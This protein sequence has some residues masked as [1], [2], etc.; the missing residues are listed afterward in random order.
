MCTVQGLYL[1]PGYQGSEDVWTHWFRPWLLQGPCGPC[2]WQV[3]LFCFHFSC[4]SHIFQCW[5]HV[6]GGQQEPQIVP[7]WFQRQISYRGHSHVGREY[8]WISW[9]SCPGQIGPFSKEAKRTPVGSRKWRHILVESPGILSKKWMNC[10]SALVPN[11]LMSSGGGCGDSLLAPNW[12][13]CH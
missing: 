10:Y 13:K 1:G 8:N 6:G 3:T 7:P 12:V 9:S 5:E 11:V 2:C 4:K